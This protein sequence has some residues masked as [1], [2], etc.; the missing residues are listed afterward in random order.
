VLSA[1]INDDTYGYCALRTATGLPA[2][3]LAA[4]NSECITSATDSLVYGTPMGTAYAETWVND[5]QTIADAITNLWLALCDAFTYLANNELSVEDT[6]TVNL[7][8]TSGV[9]S[10]AVQ[11]SGWKCLEGFNTFMGT[12]NAYIYPQVR[13]IGNQLHFKGNVIV[14]LINGGGGALAWSLSPGVDTYYGNTT[15]TPYTGDG[16]VKLNSNGSLAFN[17]DTTTNNNLSVIPTSVL[18]VGYAIDGTYAHP[19]GFKIAQRVIDVGDASTILTTLFSISID[20][21]GILRLG[22]VKDAEEGVISESGTAYSSAH[23][24]Y[25]ISHVAETEQVPNFDASGTTVYSDPTSG[26]QS[27]DIDFT[28][29]EYPFTCNANDENEIGGFQVSLNGLT[30]FIS[31]CGTLIP[32]PTD[33][34]T[35]CATT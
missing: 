23:I 11:D 5:P 30:A 29:Y 3:I 6:T 21:N 35:G 12:G 2:D 13:R 28:A 14:P 8:Y 15:V 1:L 4:V 10:A 25:L 26:V 27:V 17:W 9:L 16:G 20:A 7:T 34:C 33:P 32:T 31:P 22:L 24:N 19:S 18:P